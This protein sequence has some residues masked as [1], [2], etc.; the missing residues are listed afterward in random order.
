MDQIL[1]VTGINKSFGGAEV[2]KAVSFNLERGCIKGLIG[3]NGAGKTT[4]F[5]IITGMYQTDS[6]QVSFTPQQKA[7]GLTRMK[8]YRI[9]RVGVGRTF[10]KPAIAWH[11][12]V[13]ENVLLGAMNNRRFS[14]TG[15]GSNRPKLRGWTE[16]CLETIQ[17]EPEL[18]HDEMS[19]VTIATIK[20][21]E[22]ARALALSPQLL[23]FD[24]IC[25]GL[26]HEET[27]DLVELVLDYNSREHASV[28]FVE[29]DLRA[30]KN[31]CSQ[32]VVID[33]GAIIFD[34]EIGTAFSDDAVIQAYIGKDHAQS[35]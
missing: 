8:P 5:N 13:F 10:Q 17:I 31:L 30:V 19:K 33:F 7:Y 24:E 6:G 15:F 21:V 14:A 22:F 12:S 25:S 35:N 29:H 18:W 2:L 9:A 16:H 27:D 23:L 1:E 32:V 11:L 26:S 28:L 20:K 4:L 34:G 3:P